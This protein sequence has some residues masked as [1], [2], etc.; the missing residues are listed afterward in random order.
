M[1]LI[2]D[3][4]SLI[5][6]LRDCGGGDPETV[7]LFA[8]HLYDKP[9]HLNQVWW[10]DEN[11]TEQRWTTATVPGQRYVEPRKL[12]LL[13]SSETFS[14]CEDFAYALK[15][16]KRA[17]LIGETTGGGARGGGQHRVDVH[18]MTFL[19]SRRPISQL[20]HTDWDNVGVVPKGKTSAKNAFDM[21]QIA[22]LKVLIP[23]EKDLDWQ[24]KLK[25]RL[26]DL[27]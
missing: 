22:A 16:N 21:A 6:D 26:R 13:T 1:G 9:T 18:F 23:A 15:N 12:Y 27:K 24:E 14:G 10:R 17:T 7:M 8:S 3:T 5:I 19:P 11:R 2:S 4:S 25:H 20:T